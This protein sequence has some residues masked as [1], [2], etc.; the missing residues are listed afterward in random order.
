MRDRRRYAISLL[1]AVFLFAVVNY[2][3][4]TRPVTC[5]DC[6]FSYGLPFTFFHEGGYAG[7]RGFQ[8]IGAALDTLVVLASGVALASAWKWYSHKHQS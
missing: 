5:W 4:L 6:F 7:G 2:F 8:L 1:A 3:H